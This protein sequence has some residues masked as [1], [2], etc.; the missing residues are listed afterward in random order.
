MPRSSRPISVTLGDLHAGV[1]S[2]VTT[3][4]YASASEVLRAALRALDREEAAIDDWLRQRV[5]EAL[6]DKRPSV[7]AATVFARLRKHHARR[8]KATREAV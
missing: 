1:A 4:A 5:D 7:P 8:T 2:R 3:G 6:S